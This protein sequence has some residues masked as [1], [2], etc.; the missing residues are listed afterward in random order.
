MVKLKTK[1]IMLTCS[2]LHCKLACFSL[3]LGFLVSFV[4]CTNNFNDIN[5]PAGK[6][7]IEELQRDNYAVGSFLIQM[8]GV[9]FPEQENAYQTMID[10]VGN[11]LGRYTTYTK[12]F[13]RTIHSSMQ[14]ITGVHG[15]P[16]MHLRLF[17]LST[18]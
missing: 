12:S 5:K 13:R 9:A 11:Y 6:L 8:Q 3:L 2:K 4:S 18:K 15:Q 10:F 16:L 1:N 17:Q 7:S 14:A